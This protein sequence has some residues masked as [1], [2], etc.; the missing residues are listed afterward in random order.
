MKH[1]S[2]SLSA[3][4]LTL[5]LALTGAAFTSLHSSV[6]T[7]PGA[8]SASLS[9][10]VKTT[11]GAAF[12]SLHS[13]VKTT[14]VACQQAP[15]NLSADKPAAASGRPFA[16]LLKS[17]KQYIYYWY[18]EPDDTYNDYETL[19]NEEYELSW[20]YG[21]NLVVDTDPMGGTL[22]SEGYMTNEYPHRMFAAA[23]LY[24]HFTY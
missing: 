3:M 23:Y 2:I 15:G 21:G 1:L 16:P 14:P 9:S 6:K 13:S 20:I 19:D 11:P 5:A 17:S 7:T 22:L 12:T 10:S 24:G 4:L 18:T 8:A